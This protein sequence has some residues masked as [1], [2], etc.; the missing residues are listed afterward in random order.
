MSANFR[1]NIATV[2]KSGSRVWIYSKQPSGPLYSKRKLLSYILLVILIGTPFVKIN[3]EPIML[4]NILESRFIVF[5]VHFTTQDFH[6]FVIA[7]LIGMIFIALFTV[8]FGRI[9][10]GWVCPQTIFMEMVFRRIEYWIEGSPSAQKKL[11]KAP[12]NGNKLIKKTTKHFLFILVSSIVAHTFLAYIIGVDGLWVLVTQP[13]EQHIGGLIAM[14]IFTA[15]F[16][17]VFSIMREQV[18]TTICP[19]G[20]MQSV[21]LDKKSLVVTYD[22]IRGEPRG[23]LSKKKDACTSDQKCTHRSEGAC[24]GTHCSKFDHLAGLNNPLEEINKQVKGD[25]IDCKLCI[26]VCP[27]GID[28]RNGTQ[29]EC[30]N[31]TACIDACNEV[32]DKIDKPRGLIRYD[33]HEGVTKKSNSFKNARVYAYSSVLI[34]LLLIEGFLLFSRAEIETLVLRTPGMNY[35]ITDDGKLSNLYNYQIINKTD[36][37]DSLSFRVVSPEQ[38]TLKFIGDTPTR[39]AHQITEG[40]VFVIID[41]KYLTDRKTKIKLEI[42]SG[43]K[44]LDRTT[45]F[46]ISPLSKSK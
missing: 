37:E 6:V 32:M 13:I 4:F 24:D 45:T 11:D 33:S 17:G 31:C 35:H 10:C 23:K 2:D 36:K 3:G 42:Y 28:I 38:A 8:V 34:I 14:I 18:C 27:T 9:F 7:M 20:R 22:Y 44:I 16:Y 41:G 40:S 1:D 12:W 26:Q 30:I 5:G 43:E 39:K 25:C 29:L 46:F 21:L 19:Y 15:L